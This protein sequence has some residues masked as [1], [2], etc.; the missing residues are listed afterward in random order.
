MVPKKTSKNKDRLKRRFYEDD[1]D[2]L[3]W[4]DRARPLTKE[5]QKT[6]DEILRSIKSR[7][8]K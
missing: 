7:E 3:I 5:E 1:P 6:V 8:A 2:S 4:S